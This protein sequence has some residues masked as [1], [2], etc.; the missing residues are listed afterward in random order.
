MY[1]LMSEPQYQKLLE[2][3]AALRAADAN[4]SPE[5][6][7]EEPPDRD[8]LKKAGQTDA[9]SKASAKDTKR[10]EQDAE[11]RL[12]EEG[13]LEEGGPDPQCT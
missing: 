8:A 12:P 3:A 2:Q 1:S 11:E 13:L 4:V 9:E 10:Q 6:L 5:S 7:A